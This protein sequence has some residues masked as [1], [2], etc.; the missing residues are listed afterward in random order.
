MNSNRIVLLL[1]ACLVLQ[2]AGYFPLQAEELPGP[3]APLFCF[4]CQPVVKQTDGRFVRTL[5][6]EG[7]AAAVASAEV[8][9]THTGTD[10]VFKSVPDRGRINLVSGQR[11]F[12]NIFAVAKPSGHLMT[13]STSFYLWGNSKEPVPRTPATP[14]EV[15]MLKELPFV[16]VKMFQTRFWPQ[17]GESFDFFVHKGLDDTVP[18]ARIEPLKVM[19]RKQ[20]RALTRSTETKDS[21]SNWVHIPNHDRELNRTGA[22][23]Y[24]EDIVFSDT[25]V[26]TEDDQICISAA[27]TFMV[28]RSRFAQNSAVYGWSVLAGA[29]VF[30]SGWVIVKRRQPWWRG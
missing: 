21:G 22:V 5:T 9:Y 13:A 19:E 27:Y 7:P 28:H 23:A 10:A 20:I 15:A 1:L 26:H 4:K 6:L 14:E 12:F 2:A 11:A 16:G 30:F 8:F 3:A 24:R 29:T 25:P 18:L 17:T